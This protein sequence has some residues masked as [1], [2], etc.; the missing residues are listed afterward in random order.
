MNK[1]FKNKKEKSLQFND[2]FKQKSEAGK[3]ID[4]HQW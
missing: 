4:A 1:K 3:G 2:A